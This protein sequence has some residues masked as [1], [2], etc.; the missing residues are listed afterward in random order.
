VKVGLVQAVCGN[1]SL[2]YEVFLDK[3]VPP[4]KLQIL[5]TTAIVPWVRI[6]ILTNGF[7]EG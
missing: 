7:T 1:C 2:L 4:E 3:F 5:L 6:T